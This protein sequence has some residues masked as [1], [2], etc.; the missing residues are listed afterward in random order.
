MAWSVNVQMPDCGHIWFDPVSGGMSFV[1]NTCVDAH[2]E[3]REFIR[4]LEDR[5]S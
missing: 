5:A 1:C 4:D 3:I 2:P